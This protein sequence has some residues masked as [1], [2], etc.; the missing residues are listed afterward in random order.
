MDNREKYVVDGTTYYYINGKWVDSCYTTVTKSILF[1]LNAARLKSLDFEN[2]DFSELIKIA[3]E[4]KENEDFVLSYRLFDTLLKK[5][6]DLSVIRSILP[7]YTSTIRK[8]ERPNEAIQIAEDYINKYGKEINSSALM[9]SVAGALCD[10]GDYV[11]ARK[12]ANKARA[13]S[14]GNSSPELISVYSRI[15]SM[16]K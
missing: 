10:I 2:S 11:E 16:E 3:Q 15:K 8:L 4:M 7:R 13:L 1:K 6:D 14:A 12:K 5:T 9:T